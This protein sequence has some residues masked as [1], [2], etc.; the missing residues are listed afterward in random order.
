[1]AFDHVDGVVRS[2]R[3]EATAWTQRKVTH[4]SLDAAR[5]GPT[6]TGAD[7]LVAEFGENPLMGVLSPRV[8]QRGE[9]LPGAAACGE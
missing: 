1:M 2:A 5:H 9:W 6:A 7:L 3:A 4:L 8:V